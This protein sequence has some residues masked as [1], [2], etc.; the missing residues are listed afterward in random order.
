VC[1]QQSTE[2]KF[3]NKTADKKQEI[4]TL[5]IPPSEGGLMYSRYR[6]RYAKEGEERQEDFGLRWKDASFIARTTRAQQS[7]QTS[8]F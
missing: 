3:K 4:A 8:S 6:Y 2:N 1:Q 7:G 5:S